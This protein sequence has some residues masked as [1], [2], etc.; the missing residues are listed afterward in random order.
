[1]L[2]AAAQMQGPNRLMAGL[3]PGPG[4]R[5]AAMGE[6]HVAVARD[7]SALYWSPAGF[8]L[9]DDGQWHAVSAHYDGHH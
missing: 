1:M 2:P 4:A 8:A 5:A 7:A 3:A 6:A 9:R